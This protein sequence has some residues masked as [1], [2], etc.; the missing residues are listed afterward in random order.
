MAPGDLRDHRIVRRRSRK[1][2]EAVSGLCRAWLRAGVD[3]FSDS[4]R[5][6]TDLAGD[7]RSDDCVSDRPGRRDRDE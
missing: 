1:T 5:I 2:G 6:A 3:A 7:L 4:M